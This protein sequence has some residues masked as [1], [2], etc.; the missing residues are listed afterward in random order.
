MKAD[1]IISKAEHF[2]VS[3]ANTLLDETEQPEK[4]QVFLMDNQEVLQ[5]YLEALQ[6]IM[7]TT[8][9]SGPE[10]F[11]DDI[12]ILVQRAQDITSMLKET[13]SSYQAEL[14]VQPDTTEETTTAV[15][16][17]EN[18]EEA[19]KTNKTTQEIKSNM[20][21][22]AEQKAAP[23]IT[24]YTHTLVCDGQSYFIFAMD[25][26]TLETQIN[27]IVSTASFKDI[28]LFELKLTPVPL[29]KRTVLTV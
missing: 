16:T 13:L 3:F 17:E 24:Q 4:K 18:I 8:A 21:A 6:K 5:K 20:A 15:L 12:E 23:S 25:K 29:H 2:A 10:A 14:M 27:D 9:A 26:L 19:M 11:D 1:E 22:I 28:Q 7:E